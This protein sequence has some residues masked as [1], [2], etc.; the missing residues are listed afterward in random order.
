LDAARQAN[1]AL[2]KAQASHIYAGLNLWPAETTA[3]L[4]E[5]KLID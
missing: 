1:V 3:R 5:A 4:V 2:A